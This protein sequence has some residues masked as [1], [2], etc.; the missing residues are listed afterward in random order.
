[1]NSSL[2]ALVLA[3]GSGTRLWPLSRKKS[4]KQLLTLI[5]DRTMFRITI[6]RLAPL[7]PLERVHVV[8]N[9]EMA[10]M[11]R[12]QEPGIPEENYIIEPSAKDS[13]PATGLSL[14][15]ISRRDPNATIVI[16][17]ADHHIGRVDVFLKAL[18]S[19][20]QVAQQGYIVTLGITPNH[21]STGFGYIERG[22]SI[23][24]IGDFE[25]Y[26]TIRFTEKPSLEV[27]Q[28]WIADGQHVW[29]S[30][31]FIFK[32]EAGWQEFARQ[33]PAFEAALRGVSQ[34]IGTP[35]YEE[36]RAKAWE[37]APKKSIDFAIMEGAQRMAV[38]PVDM[39]WNDIGTWASL[40][41][42]MSSDKSGNVIIGDYEGADTEHT[43]IRGGHRLIAT[44]GL[45]N[46]VIVDTP[47]VLLICPTE[48]VQEVKDMVEQLRAHKRTDV[49]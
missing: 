18:E 16:V 14:A 39:E 30:G 6:D 33:Q 38:I 4:P 22:E 46:L 5:G 36:A 44:I 15:H 12:E 7:I 23:G 11:L 2:H 49:L 29:N 37:A 10:Q 35:G 34:A 20:Y 48:R 8:T 43:L 41:D 42:V 13:G 26:R 47:D 31:M 21:P 45:S 1:V 17:S 27:A 28:K 9:I 24:A 25:A 40:L 3:G 19:A 32:C